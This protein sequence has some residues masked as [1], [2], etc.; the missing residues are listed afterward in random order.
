MVDQT[1]AV[2][3][4]MLQGDQIEVL[5]IFFVEQKEILTTILFDKEQK[6]QVKRLG[7]VVLK[8]VQ[9][10]T[11]HKVEGEALLELLA[12]FAIH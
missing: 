2:Q 9:H 3:D 1:L 6:E 7:K 5:T 4:R 12:D 11:Y 8:P 10:L